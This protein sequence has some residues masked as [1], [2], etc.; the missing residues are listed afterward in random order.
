MKFIVDYHICGD[1]KNYNCWTMSDNA[2]PK[3]KLFSFLT[4]GLIIKNMNTCEPKFATQVY[5]VADHVWPQ[6]TK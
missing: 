2:N 5:A 4:K 3:Y 6:L 1:I